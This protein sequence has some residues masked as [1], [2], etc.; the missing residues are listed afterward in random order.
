MRWKVGI[1]EPG[2]RS[3]GPDQIWTIPRARI[4]RAIVT[5]VAYSARASMPRSNNGRMS[6]RSTIIPSTKTLSPATGTAMNQRSGPRN[7][8]TTRYWTKLPIM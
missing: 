6:T 5:T 1:V 7:R 4:A 8:L 3:N 2:E